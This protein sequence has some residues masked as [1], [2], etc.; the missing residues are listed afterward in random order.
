MNKVNIL[1]STDDN[2]VPYCGIM[3]TSLFENNKELDIEVYLMCESL[4]EK[5]LDD[6]NLLSKKYSV[7]IQMVQVDNTVFKDC[8]IR[9]NDHVSLVA[10]YRLIA[11]DVLPQ[12]INKIL[13]LDCDI[14]LNGCIKKLY[15]T[16]ISEYAFGAVIDED[17]FNNEKYSRLNYEKSY[18]YINSG[19]ILF[20]LDYW[21]KHNI[22]K[23]C[24]DYIS[25]YPDRIK[26]HDQDTINVVCRKQKKL[27]PLIYNF[28]TGFLLTDLYFN[29]AVEDDI[30]SSSKSPVIIHY[31]GKNKPWMRYSQQPF[32]NLFFKYKKMSLWHSMPLIKNLNTT[33]VIRYYIYLLILLIKNKRKYRRYSLI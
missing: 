29:K 13:Y 24:F 33:K 32:R 9:P 6:L 2:Y 22:A 3:L 30:M 17:V 26:L 25:S 10:Y 7:N 31:T 19:V 20:N 27:L 18:K 11:A 23:E 15:D 28:Q 16:D 12:N 14:I 1:C 8:P 4:N 5:N 21:K